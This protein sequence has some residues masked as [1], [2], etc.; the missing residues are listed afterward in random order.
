MAATEWKNIRP[1]LKVCY[2]IEQSGGLKREKIELF[3]NDNMIID[4]QVFSDWLGC[5]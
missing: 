4:V 2:L 5:F 3:L 1:G